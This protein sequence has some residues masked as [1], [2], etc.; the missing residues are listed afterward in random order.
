MK[1]TSNDFNS[2][3]N[4]MR[5]LRFSKDKAMA[6]WAANDGLSSV[7]IFNVSLVTFSLILA[8]TFGT[9]GVAT[10]ETASFVIVKKMKDF[11]KYSHVGIPG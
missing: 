8:E 10:Y 6:S 3:L 5:K 11:F 4:G 7:R 1:V 9:E 2:V